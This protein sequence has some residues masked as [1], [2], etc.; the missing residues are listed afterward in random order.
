MD[1]WS[2]MLIFVKL[3][4]RASVIEGQLQIPKPLLQLPAIPFLPVEQES[5]TGEKEGAERDAY[6]DTDGGGGGFCG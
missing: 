3:W 4:D 1:I 2:S 5:E 6:A